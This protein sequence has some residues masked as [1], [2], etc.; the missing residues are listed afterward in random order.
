MHRTSLEFN[1]EG[2]MEEVFH[3]LDE[4]DIHYATEMQELSHV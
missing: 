1:N 4:G 2:D 3:Y